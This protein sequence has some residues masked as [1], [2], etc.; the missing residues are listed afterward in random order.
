MGHSGRF[1]RG[2]P[3]AT[4]CITHPKLITNL[5][6]AVFVCDQNTGYEAYSF[7]TAGYGI[8]N[9]RTKLDACRTHEESAQRLTRR[10]RKLPHQGIKPRVFGFEFRHTNH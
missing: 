1:P 3:A 2:K 7:T 8:F 10:D 9:V 6:Y 5:V 4:E